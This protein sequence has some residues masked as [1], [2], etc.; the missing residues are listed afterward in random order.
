MSAVT[1]GMQKQA[2][3]ET[4]VNMESDPVSWKGIQPGALEI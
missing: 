2:L 4:A 1:L 3:C